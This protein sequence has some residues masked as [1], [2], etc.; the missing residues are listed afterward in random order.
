MHAMVKSSDRMQPPPRSR[1]GD[2]TRRH[3][4][5]GAAS[6]DPPRPEADRVTFG[7]LVEHGLAKHMLRPSAEL[8]YFVKI[9]T[10]R[11][12]RVFWSP[13]LKAA[14]AQSHTQ[15]QVGDE[16][17]V[18]E[19]SIQPATLITRVRDAQ[20]NVVGERRYDSSRVHWRVEKRA[21]FD[22]RML[23]A[24]MLRNERMHP[25]EAVRT[26]PE[27]LP[28]YLMLDS[29]RKVAARDIAAANR[30]RFVKLVRE[31]VA[32]AL[33]R[34]EPLPSIGLRMPAAQRAPAAER[35]SAAEHA[36]PGTAR[37]R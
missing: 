27:L 13:Q 15:P 3:I 4:A 30:E 18:R 14:M 21:F 20:G 17:G 25:R 16:I 31:T 12:E 1:D 19:N 23:A 9:E 8:S 24:E 7:R 28:A 10:A 22:E 29:A 26:Y 2:G 32:H 36:P 6:L 37:E 33:E 5:E 35:P 34:G 11:G